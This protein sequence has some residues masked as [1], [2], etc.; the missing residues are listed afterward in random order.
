MDFKVH[1]VAEMQKQ[2]SLSLMVLSSMDDLGQDPLVH[3]N[4]AKQWFLFF[5]QSRI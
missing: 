3:E 5:Y 1:G 4:V 2:L